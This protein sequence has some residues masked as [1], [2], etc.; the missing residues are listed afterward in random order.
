MEEQK[1]MIKEEKKKGS[2]ESRERE[3]RNEGGKPEWKDRGKIMIKVD[4]KLYTLIKK[5]AIDRKKERGKPQ[6]RK[7]ISGLLSPHC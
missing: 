3:R 1:M 6:K 2:E 7:L 4:D 5:K